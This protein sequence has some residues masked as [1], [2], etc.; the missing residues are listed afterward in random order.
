MVVINDTVSNWALVTTGVLQGSVLERV[1]FIIY[2]NGIDVVLNI[3]ISHSIITD[4]DSMS[5]QKDLRKI[6][7]FFQRWEMPFDVNNC[8]VLQV[9]TKNQEID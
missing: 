2:I 4:H 9:A 1:L 5:L 8:H 3:F 6:S 7:E